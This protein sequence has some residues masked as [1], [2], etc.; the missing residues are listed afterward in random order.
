M[1]IRVRGWTVPIVFSVF[2]AL[3]LSSRAEPAGRQSI[4]LNTGWEF[5]QRVDDPN[6]KEAQWRP[7]EVPGAVHTDLLRNGIIPDP[8]YRENEARLQWIENAD[9]EYR[10]RIDA[11]PEMLAR[12]NVELVFEGLDAYA[13]VYVNAKLVLTADN[14]FRQWRVDLKPYLKPGANE[15]LVVFPSVIKAAA[16]IAAMDKWHLPTQVEDKTYI[17]KAAYEYGWDWGP[18]FVT[19][20]IWRPVRL[21]LW[22]DARISDLHIRQRDVAPEVARLTV[23]VEVT[24]AVQT[25]AKVILEYGHEGKKQ[26]LSRIVELHAGIN[27]IDMPV[28]IAQPDLWYPAGYGAQPMYQFDA[29]LESGGRLEDERTASTGIRSVVLRREVDRWGRSFEFVVNGIP[30][31][32]KGANL[33]PF[34]SFPAR[35]TTQR[36]R[37]ILQAARDAN[38]NM[39][40]AWGGGYYETDEFYRLCDELGIMVWQEF[41]F[42]NDWQPGTYSF[43]LN[44]AKEAQDQLRRLRN[45]PCIVLWCGNNETEAAFEWKDRGKLPAEIRRHMWQDY[46][47]VFSGLLARAV[48]R[49]SPE[50]PYWPSSPSAD[51]EDTSPSY[52]SGDMHNW[53]V[54]HG[55]VPFRDYEKSNPRFMSEYGFQSFPEMRTIESFTIPED[56]TGITSPVMLAHQKNAAGNAIIHDYMLRDYPEPK[57]FASF[58]YASQV[59]QAEGIKIGAEHLRRNRPRSMGSLYWQLND[60]WPV[61]S[62]S[63]LDY[64][65]R[66]KA[67]HYYARR[68]YNDL[69]VSPHQENGNLAV[70]VVS[71]KTTATAA[72]LRVRIMTVEGKVLSDRTQSVEI[73]PLSSKIYAQLPVDGI[74]KGEGADPGTTFAV[75]DLIVGGKEASS[76]LMFFVETKNVRLPHANIHTQLSRA[77][78]SYRLRLTSDVLARSVYVSF[79]NVEPKLSDNY[80]DLLPGK[81]VEIEISSTAAL[82]EL[83]TQ[84]KVVSLADTFPNTG[85]AQK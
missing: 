21:E 66:W 64:D 35:V 68:F 32:A 83:E 2:L 40:R 25:S 1:F 65:G 74:L 24:A 52:Q 29:R 84:L 79:T 85:T 54:W 37:Q 48:E 38:M 59:L 60:C 50:T 16:K 6:A 82:K 56:R 81:A 69:L 58:L 14:M 43:K 15:L 11:T 70:Y 39:V 5:H 9:W 63:S 36:Y 57:D 46:V 12:R 10:G 49:L 26:E 34:D 30:V 44:V 7:A 80:F 19:C 51:F 18:R 45:H 77:G 8:F 20:G 33:I 55:R 28:E 42:G 4:P 61:A 72:D 75:T 31:F 76:N 67:L 47:S 62:W 71:D 13:E 22:D 73:P 53:D 17:R 23:T 41:M 78:D 27:N 3:S